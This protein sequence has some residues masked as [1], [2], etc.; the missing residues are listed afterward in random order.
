MGGKL[1]AEAK[2][3]FQGEKVE[4]SSESLSKLEV[5]MEDEDRKSQVTVR[6]S[7]SI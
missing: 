4:D 7:F 1:S 6:L 5:W 2:G 3:S